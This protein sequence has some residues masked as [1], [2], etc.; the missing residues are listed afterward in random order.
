MLAYL[1]G[2]ASRCAR[3]LSSLTA[4]AREIAST[5]DLSGKMPTLTSDDE[6]AE[7]GRTL[8]DMLRSLDQARSETEQ[9]MKRQREFVAD[10][11]HEPARR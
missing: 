6:V 9:S 11:S 5:G 7:L 2:L 8:E 4:A 10:A 1:A 3:C